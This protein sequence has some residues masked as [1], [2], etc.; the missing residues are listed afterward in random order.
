MANTSIA[1]KR[2]GFLEDASSLNRHGLW[3][4]LVCLDFYESFSQISY[5]IL[6]NK[7]DA[8][9][10]IIE[11]NYFTFIYIY[12]YMYLHQFN[13]LQLLDF[14]LDAMH[15]VG[16]GA[17][18]RLFE[19]LFR[20]LDSRRLPKIT[21]EQKT[22]AEKALEK[23]NEY[24][25]EWRKPD[26]FEREVR[27][28]Q[29]MK[30]WKMREAHEALL[31][32]LVA[33]LLIPEIREGI[34]EEACDAAMCLVVGLQLIYQSTHESPSEY[35][36]DEAER[37]I[38]TFFIKFVQIYKK[39]TVSYKMHC[40]IHLPN[41]CRIRKSHLGGFDCYAYESWLGKVKDTFVLTGKGVVQQFKNNLTRHAQHRLPLDLDGK[42][43]SY[44]LSFDAE[45]EQM[46][47]HR[48]L[49]LPATDIHHVDFTN[50]KVYCRGFICSTK[51]VT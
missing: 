26:E 16:G 46:V 29:N 34:G 9:R 32:H 22:K 1:N 5:L 40:L 41:E 31:Y 19:C 50:Q 25:K 38:K 24:M 14:A 49:N 21:R 18:K 28:L 27:P 3:I 51:F 35:D 4:R 20:F 10:I 6:I 37:Q 11:K 12:K 33:L 2:S 30:H 15:I 17:V 43:K 45:L 48:T 47:L 39:D 13:V 8:V 44:R 42:V 7:S 36:M 23:A